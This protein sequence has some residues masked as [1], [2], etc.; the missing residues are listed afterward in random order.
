VQVL[1]GH[2]FDTIKTRAQS[3]RH[4]GVPGG[5]VQAARS[6]WVTDGARGFYRGVTP[7]LILTGVKRSA[8][9]AIWE[10]LLRLQSLG[11]NSSSG[12]SVDSKTSGGTGKGSSSGSGLHKF[13][14]GAVSGVLGSF[15]G[16]PMH[17]VKVQTQ[18]ASSRETRSALT[19]AVDIFRTRGVRGF[20]AGFAAHAV[21]DAAFASVYLGLYGWM[22]SKAKE[23]Q[24]QQRASTTT[25]DAAPLPA[26]ANA[27]S[28]SPATSSIPGVTYTIAAGAIA[29]TATWAL[30]LPLDTIKTVAQS[31]RYGSA[32]PSPSEAAPSMSRPAAAGGEYV[33]GSR[34]AVERLFHRGGG[35][36]TT[37]A[38]SARGYAELVAARLWSGLGPALMRAGPANG[39]S[40]AA[41]E[42]CLV[43]CNSDE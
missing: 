34:D 25:S 27:S 29:A 38:V 4:S 15:I 12:S 40:M 20:Y 36:A 23:L 30:L 28:R 8:Q 41:Y 31:G 7:P 35:A 6:I 16:A 17:V 13:A 9:M 43:A 19:C 5:S 32:A 33:R 37:G 3:L 10:A 2:P 21:K 24:Q 26:S 22:R 39:L 11:S 42:A 18:L 14:A 1:V